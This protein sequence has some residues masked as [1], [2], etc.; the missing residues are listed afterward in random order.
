M[1]SVK[2]AQ[3][4]RPEFRV[5]PACACLIIFD[6]TTRSIPSFVSSSHSFSVHDSISHQLFSSVV[7]S[8]FHSSKIFFLVSLSFLLF[9]VLFSNSSLPKAI[10]SSH[11][12]R[13]TDFQAPKSS[14][15][16]LLSSGSSQKKSQLPLKSPHLPSF[17]FIPAISTRPPVLQNRRLSPSLSPLDGLPL[18]TL[19]HLF[20]TILYTLVDSRSSAPT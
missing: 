15:P 7:V 3:S 12:P 18:V 17:L 2:A 6:L 16:S 10:S 9:F 19:N 20:L 4:P 1:Q 11:L 8:L 5:S 14:T 13:A